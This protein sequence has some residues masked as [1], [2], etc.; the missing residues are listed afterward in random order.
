MIEPEAKR[1]IARV[2]AL[3]PAIGKLVGPYLRLFANGK[4]GVQLRRAVALIDELAAL[5]DAG[6]V[7]RDE[8]VG[9]RRP[10][11]PTMWA[12]GMEQMIGQPP[13]GPLKNH[14]YLRAIVFGLADSADAQA[15]R[16]REQSARAGRRVSGSETR[17]ADDPVTIALSWTRQ[18]M[19]LG[20]M[21]QEEAD[22]YVAKI[23]GKA[24]ND[25]GAR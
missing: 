3:E 2:A 13:S 14:H 20:G 6:E 15:E 7:C 21:T 5:V 11:S 10:A 18:Q 16:A 9:V 8:R 1:A 17:V 19:E 12:T 4:R 23:R 25:E 22:A 24:R